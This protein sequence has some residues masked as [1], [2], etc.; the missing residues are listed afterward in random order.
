MDPD[1]CPGCGVEVTVISF[2]IQSLPVGDEVVD[3]LMMT[4]QNCGH[5]MPASAAAREF[6]D[7]YQ[8]GDVE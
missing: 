5:T 8:S 7:R 6:F 1:V 2:V 3:T 4:S